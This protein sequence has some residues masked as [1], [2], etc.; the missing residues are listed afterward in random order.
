[1]TVES[2]T[3][4]PTT[5]ALYP[6]ADGDETTAYS[7]LPSEPPP[8]SV[9]LTDGLQGTAWQR[10]HGDRLWHSSTGRTSTWADLVER[11]RQYDRGGPLLVHLAPPR[12]PSKRASRR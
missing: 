4:Y 5:V 10:L 8:G 11:E 2:P 6:Y 7:A 1:M 9:V 12:T 3:D